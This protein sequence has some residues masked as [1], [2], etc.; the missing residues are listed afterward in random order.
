M[1][2]MDEVKVKILLVFSG[3]H[4]E[5][6]ITIGD[7]QRAII[8]NIALKEPVSRILNKNKVYGYQSEG[9][10]SIREKMRRMRAEVMPIL[11]EQGDVVDDCS[12]NVTNGDK[13]LEVFT[14][15]HEQ[16]LHL[17][18]VHLLH[19]VEK[20]GRGGNDSIFDL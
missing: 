20:R 6:L 14:A 5:G 1:K 9:K 2:Q 17:H 7:I 13:P 18:L 15:E 10:E 19:G 8:N 12:L 3:E 4:F 11:D 16:Y